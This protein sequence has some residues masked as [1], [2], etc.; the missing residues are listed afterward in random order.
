MTEGGKQKRKVERG[1]IG[2]KQ[3]AWKISCSG[4][5][6]LAIKPPLTALDLNAVLHS[7]VLDI[8]HDLESRVMKSTKHIRDQ[9]YNARLTKH[10]F[11]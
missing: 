9:H 7:V 5:I 11:T 10:S 3:G 4:D 2:E 1:R 8:W 6:L